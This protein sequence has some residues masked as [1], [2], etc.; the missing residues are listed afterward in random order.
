MKERLMNNFGLKILAF[1]SAVLLW[2]LVVNIDNPITDQTYNNIPV[3]VVNAEVL[4]NGSS[5]KTFQIVDDTQTVSVTVRAKRS[6]LSKIEPD[7]IVAVADMKELAL[8]SQIPIQV[9]VKNHEYREAF[10]TPR[11][12]QIKLENEET[13]KFPIVPKTTGTVRDGYVLGDI[14]AE[15]EKVSI[16]GPK[17]VID[18]I[19]R[20]EATVNVSGLSEDSVLQSELVLYDQD[21]NEIDQKLLATNLGT[22][23]VSINVKLLR[24]KNVSVT[25]DTSKLEAAEGYEVAGITYEPQKINVSGE[26]EAL[27]SV[28]EISVPASALRMSGLKEKQEKMVDISKYLP[29]GIK[30]VEENA[31]SIMVTIAVEKDGTKAFD[32][33]MGSIEVNNLAKGLAMQYEKAEALEILVRGPRAEL[34]ELDIDAI[35]SIDLKSYTE[36]GT[37]VVPVLVELPERCSLEKEVSVTIILKEYHE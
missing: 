18:Q 34:E 29:E 6:V 13:K 33:T 3:T 28:S 30:L 12:L 19:N 17:S 4:A 7:D 37:Y 10:S 31:G 35:V 26:K 32:L 15:P 1:L 9:T 2:L 27:E 21:N 11:N 20:V 16:R 36:P 23:G 25:F 14:T 24:T 22:P 8:E 5:K